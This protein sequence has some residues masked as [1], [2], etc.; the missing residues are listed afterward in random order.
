MP[1]WDYS[2]EHKICLIFTHDDLLWT[3]TMIYEANTDDDNLTSIA[4]WET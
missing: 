3:Q 2:V 1:N 4:N